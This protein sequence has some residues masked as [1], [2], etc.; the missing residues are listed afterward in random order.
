MFKAL[1]SSHKTA[2]Q[3]LSPAEL[4]ERLRNKESLIMLDVRT[5]EEYKHE[6]H[7]AGARLMPLS[8][9]PVRSNELP[10]DTPIVC[11]C[12]SGS[13]SQVACESL[14]KQGFTNVAN[15]SGGMMAWRRAGLPV[16]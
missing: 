4:K 13:R 8:V 10:H 14:R 3:Q 12:R 11:V 7:I 5:P 1:F 15:M 2:I 6:G 9:V 16:S